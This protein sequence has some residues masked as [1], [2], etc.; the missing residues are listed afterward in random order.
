MDEVTQQN[1]ALVEEAAAAAT[2]L[3]EQ[4]RA[5]LETVGAFKVDGSAAPAHPA[6]AHHRAPARK[7]N[8]AHKHVGKKPSS[9]PN[10]LVKT[11]AVAA[12]KDESDWETF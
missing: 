7:P 11:A 4:S 9:A 2:S 12:V 6:P 10:S 8:I 1:A 5:L 3:E